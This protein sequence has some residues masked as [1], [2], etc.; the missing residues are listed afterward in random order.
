[1]RQLQ[2]SKVLPYFIIVI[3]ALMASFSVASILLP[4][5][6]IDYGTAGIAIIISKL[7]GL[8]LSVCVAL[9]FIPFL[10]SGGLHLGKEFF[11]RALCGSLFYT[12]GLSFF[13]EIS[14]EINTEH[15]IAVVIG[16]AIL[17]IGLS[18]ILRAGG[19]IDGSEILAS[20][21][22]KKLSE[23]NNRNYSLTGVLI[24]FNACVYLAAF[25]LINKNSALMSLIVYFAATMV[26]DHFTDHYEAVKQVTIISKNPDAIIEA[27]RHEMNKTCTVIES[28]GAISG[29]NK[30]VICYVNYFE[31]QKLRQ[32]IN[33][34]RGASF[35]TVSTIDE[36]IK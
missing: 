18:L 28:Q 15:F 19:C 33:E 23:K 36:I 14:I 31:L 11:C 29:N 21:I 1:M 24:A 8:N 32:I 4:N 25:V 17:G 16:G 6:A 22:V 10:I 12:L 3:G 9:V 2:N 27:M 20:I 30:T 7:S 35:I 34:K 26:I 5:D 13:E